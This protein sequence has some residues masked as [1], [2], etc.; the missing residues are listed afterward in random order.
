MRYVVTVCDV[1]QKEIG[2]DDFRYVFHNW[3]YRIGKYAKFHMCEKC[4][5]KFKEFVK[6]GK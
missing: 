6:V 4:F 5:E 2:S 1:C 3:H